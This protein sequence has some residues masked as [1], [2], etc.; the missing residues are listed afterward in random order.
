MT[1]AERQRRYRQKIRAKQK[2]AKI[3]T[4]RERK[5]VRFKDPDYLRTKAEHDKAES[6]DPEHERKK[7]LA[8]YGHSS[9]ECILCDEVFDGYLCPKCGLHVNEQEISPVELD[10]L[11]SMARK[12]LARPV[13]GKRL[14]K[15]FCDFVGRRTCPPHELLEYFRTA[16]K[17]YLH[18]E[19]DI[20][21]MLNLKLRQGD[22]GLTEGK[23]GGAAIELLRHLLDGDKHEW[24]MKYTKKAIGL[25]Q[26][27][28]NASWKRYRLDALHT[29]R[30]ERAAAGMPWTQEEMSLL[31]KIY[32][33]EPLIFDQCPKC[34]A[35]KFSEPKGY[36][37]SE[38]AEATGQS[39]HRIFC[40]FQEGRI[41]ATLD[42][43]GEL[44]IDPAG[45]YKMFSPATPHE[46]AHDAA[47]EASRSTGVCPA[48]G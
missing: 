40:A 48:C 17:D 3:E 26:T 47:P 29:L 4:Q 25:G 6:V 46:P 36:S 44:R 31:K 22:H 38:A 18:K 34:G 42:D 24:A 28:I 9:T 21:R 32:Q 8:V 12:G 39:K 41:T 15:A 27:V 35:I 11:L 10:E 23:R 13:D 5:S 1:A 14:L 30:A 37:V 19:S 16:F 2:Q 20:Y 33:S 7:R 43:A 45:L